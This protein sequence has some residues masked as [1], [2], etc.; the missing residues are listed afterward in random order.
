MKILIVD[1]EYLAVDLIESFLKDYDFVEQIFKCNNGYDA[2]KIINEIKPEIVFLDIQMP[3]LTGIEVIELIERPVEVIF[4]TAYEEYAIMAFER[5]A[6]D[7][8][9]KPFSKSR[10]DLSMH[11]AV[12]NIQIKKNTNDYKKVVETYNS[13]S[14]GTNRIVVKHGSKIII[15]PTNEIVC[16]EAA[17]DYIVISTE[18]GEYI[19]NSTMKYFENSLNKND[20]VRVHRSAIVNVNKIKEIQP[21][22]KDTYSLLMSNGKRIKTSRQGNSELRRILDF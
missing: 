1:D 12:E 19:K 22:T 6:T 18:S 8:L 10:F 5:N 7:Y 16:I 17:D 13:I 9:L 20:F 11:K 21:Y 15:I 14:G 2:I 4:T 3:K